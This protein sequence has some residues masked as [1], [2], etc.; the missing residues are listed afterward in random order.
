MAIRF[1]VDSAS[2]IL[3]A[4]AARMGLIHIPMKVLFGTREFSDAV[5]LTHREFY[6]KLVESDVLPTTSQIPPGEF[7][8]AYEHV[9]AEGDT[10]VVVTVSG[11]LSGTYQSAV[12]AAADYE[13]QVFVVDSESVSLG[14]RILVQRGLALRDAGLSAEEI[15]QALDQEKKTIRVMALLEVVR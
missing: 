12:I 11:K 7:Q 9:V 14:Q 1:I 5:D 13:G 3:P 6:E 10:A 8:A 4:E 15:V 2:D